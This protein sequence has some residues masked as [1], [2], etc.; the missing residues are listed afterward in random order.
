VTTDSRT[1]SSI[2]SRMTRSPVKGIWERLHPQTP[3]IDRKKRSLERLTRLTEG[4]M[5]TAS[6]GGAAEVG[7]SPNLAGGTGFLRLLGYCARSV[8]V[9]MRL[10][11]TTQKR[12]G[13]RN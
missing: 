2:P 4:A 3:E 9:D 10:H 8:T 13:A 1:E 7:D 11:V 6:S 12:R 5:A